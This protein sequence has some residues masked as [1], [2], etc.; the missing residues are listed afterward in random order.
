MIREVSGMTRAGTIKRYGLLL[1]VCFLLLLLSPLHTNAADVKKIQLFATDGLLTLPD[2]KQLYMWGYSLENK[3]G[4]AVFPGPL[5]EVEEGDT[6]EVTVTHI[7]AKQAGSE[8]RVYPLRFQGIDSPSGAE[9]ALALGQSHTRQIQAVQAGSYYYYAGDGK[10][11]GVQMGMSGPFVVKAKG[12]QK[13]AWTG[14]P[15]YDKEYVFHVNEL[16]PAWHKSAADGLVYD[17]GKFHPRYWTINGKSFPD[18]EDDP[19]SMIHGKV[20]EKILVR[21]INPG[22]DEHPMHL[23]GHHFQVIAENG[24]PRDFPL[25]KDTVNLDPGETKDILIVFD[26]S[27]NYPFHS[28]QIVDN[29]NDGVYP[30]GLHTMTHI[31]EAGSSEGSTMTL[32]IGSTHA[33]VNGEHVMLDVAPFR[34]KG[35]TYVPL[36]FIAE[37]LGGVLKART[38][39]RSLTYKTEHTE[40]ELWP[41]QKQALLNGKQV[42]LESPILQKKGKTMAPVSYISSFLCARVGADN[43]SNQIQ[44]DYQLGQECQSSGPDIT[45]PTV[46][47]DPPGGTYT[48][49]QTVQLSIQDEDPQAKIYYTTDGTLPT[50]RSLLYTGPIVIDRTTTLKWI[51]IDTSGNASEVQTG[52]YTIRPAPEVLVDV[53]DDKFTPA[54]IKVTRGTTVTWILKGSMMH[55]VTSY[56]GVMNGIIE[57]NGNK[58]FSYTFND[59]GVTSYFCMVHPYMTGSVTVE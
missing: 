35:E 17:P 47:A 53:L 7:G 6:L 23:H 3:Q 56:D 44:I 2:G 1:A 21:L 31:E 27:G 36:G 11:Y 5:L 24:V 52:V 4:T 37:Q 8:F 33:T 22:Y 38:E 55:T 18:L 19:R 48:S 50:A 13:R 9:Q 30:G 57:P 15:Q 28:H 58:R 42:Q 34:L 12:A 29:T 51:G 40:M 43:S 20:G 16:D 49:A 26:Q 54:H 14:G 32:D 25:E 59:T 45:P 39:D 41:L 46:T 10:G